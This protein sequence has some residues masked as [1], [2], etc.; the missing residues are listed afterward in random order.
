MVAEEVDPRDNNVHFKV[1]L[2]GS[3]V[4]KN[5]NYLRHYIFD[6]DFGGWSG[7]SNALVPKQ[8]YPN[9]CVCNEYFALTSR[10]CLNS[11]KPNNP[12]IFKRFSENMIGWARKFKHLFT[13]TGQLD[14]ETVM[15]NTRQS[16]KMRY[17]KAYDNLK[18][19]RH[20]L[21]NRF[22]RLKAFI[23]I[24]QT[25]LDK[26]LTKPARLI[27]YRSFEYG[28][29]FKSFLLNFDLVVKNEDNYQSI[30]LPNS[31]KQPLKEAWTKYNTDDVQMENLIKAWNRYKRPIAILIDHSKYDGHY[32]CDLVRNEREF[33][34]ELLGN[35]KFFDWLLSCQENNSGITANGLKYRVIGKRASGDPNT[36]A[37]NTV[38]NTFMIITWCSD[39]G[40][41][42]YYIY[43]NGDDSMI[44]CEFEDAQKLLQLGVSFFRNLYMETEI[45]G[46][47]T[48][49]EEIVYCQRRPV[50]LG[51][52]YRWVTDPFRLLGRFVVSEF[53]YKSSANR[54]LLGKA[55]CMLHCYHGAPIIQTFLLRVIDDCLTSDPSLRPLGS[56]DKTAA[57]SQSIDKIPLKISEIDNAGRYSFFIAFGLTPEYQ[58]KIEND[59][60]AGPQISQFVVDF[61]NKYKFFCYN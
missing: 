45:E 41:F 58:I 44:I 5:Q 34:K 43:I 30:Y 23:K 10:H 49:L 28:Y 27:Q 11:I 61:I 56:V 9:P 19:N 40:V 39:A 3:R 12:G 48:Q 35:K 57:R 14:N 53:K 50:K 59:L 16:K 52:V 46:I 13:N 51:G 54:Y 20:F 8:G 7:T 31:N 1:Q 26:L 6:G 4:H 15:N 18:N 21:D 33:W 24:E 55:L 60:A 47:A 2:L 36:S 42:D 38:S 29:C 22:S 17:V 37:G 32:E 25:T